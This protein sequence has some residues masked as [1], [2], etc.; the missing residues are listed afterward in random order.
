M[1]SQAEHM[2]QKEMNF[3]F[4]RISDDIENKMQDWKELLLKEFSFS[5]EL[6]ISIQTVS[7]IDFYE[8]YMEEESEFHYI[9]EDTFVFEAGVFDGENRYTMYLGLSFLDDRI[10]M[11]YLTAMTPMYE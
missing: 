10:V 11:S 9:D 4:E 2:E 1:K 3:D 7:N 6:P 5:E 8:T